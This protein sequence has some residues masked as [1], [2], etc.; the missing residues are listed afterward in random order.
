MSQGQG[1]T[2]WE[3]LIEAPQAYS[4]AFLGKRSKTNM[5]TN[6][7][8]SLFMRA[9]RIL[10]YLLWEFGNSYSSTRELRANSHLYEFVLL[11][12][13]LIKDTR[14]PIWIL[15][16]EASVSARTLIFIIF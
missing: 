14:A 5:R 12:E 8:H 3:C 15:L 16:G 6:S 7:S 2:C 11:W 13:L 9:I 4:Y 1:L 10:S